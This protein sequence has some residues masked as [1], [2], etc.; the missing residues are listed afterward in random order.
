MNCPN[1]KETIQDN[2]LVCPFCKEPISEPVAF[3]KRQVAL[4]KDVM[5]I[6]EDIVA[7]EKKDF[8]YMWFYKKDI[9]KQAKSMNLNNEKQEDVL[10]ILHKDP[11][12]IGNHFL[13]WFFTMISGLMILSIFAR[14]YISFTYPYGITV[15]Q[16]AYGLF[17]IGFF[18]ILLSVWKIIRNKRLFFPLIFVIAHLL[19][20]ASI[21]YLHLIALAI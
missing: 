6:Y 2:L 11:K 15:R 9:Y 8:D 7:E 14:D 5:K 18:V 3:R 16:I 12:S 21:G 1:C 20:V 19:F 13:E 4:N 10:D 17:G